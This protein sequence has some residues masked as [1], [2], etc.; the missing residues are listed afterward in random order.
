LSTERGYAGRDSRDSRDSRD[1]AFTTL[2]I[3]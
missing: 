2:L 1:R 3:L